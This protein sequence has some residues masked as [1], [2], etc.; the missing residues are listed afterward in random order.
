[1][2]SH[3]ILVVSDNFFFRTS[4]VASNVPVTEN[5]ERISPPLLVRFPVEL[6]CPGASYL[7]THWLQNPQQKFSWMKNQFSFFEIQHLLTSFI[8]C[9][10]SIVRGCEQLTPINNF[11]VPP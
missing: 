11:E 1:M 9:T 6:T 4:S 7:H 8:P 2:H 3:T 10:S 5:S